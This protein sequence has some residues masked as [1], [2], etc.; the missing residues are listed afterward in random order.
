MKVLKAARPVPPFRPLPPPPQGAVRAGAAVQSLPAP[1]LIAVPAFQAL[2]QSIVRAANSAPRPPAPQAF[3]SSSNQMANR[4]F[5]VWQSSL[6]VYFKRNKLFGTSLVIDNWFQLTSGFIHITCF[7][8]PC[9]DLNLRT[10]ARGV[11]TLPR[12]IPQCVVYHLIKES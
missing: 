8:R 6:C 9:L 10:H 3:Q 12:V 2:P 7:I 1:A 4:R 11:S 5:Q